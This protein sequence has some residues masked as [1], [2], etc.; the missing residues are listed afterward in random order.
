MFSDL[1]VQ[2]AAKEQIEIF[3]SLA[4]LL[5]CKLESA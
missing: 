1:D 3:Q 5:L 4:K 2:R